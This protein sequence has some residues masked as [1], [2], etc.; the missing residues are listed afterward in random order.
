MAEL[1]ARLECVQSS[2]ETFVVVCS[3]IVSLSSD[4]REQ[5]YE[6]RPKELHSY[7]QHCD[8]RPDQQ[9]IMCV[10]TFWEPWGYRALEK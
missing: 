4:T 5:F 2:L 1:I 3:S 9:E 6:Q 10:N 8:I 7:I